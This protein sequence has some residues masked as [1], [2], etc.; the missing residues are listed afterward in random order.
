PVFGSSTPLPAPGPVAVPPAIVSGLPLRFSPVDVGAIQSITALGAMNP[1][2]HT[3]PTDHIYFAHHFNT[4]PFPPV[5][6]V[7]PGS[8]TVESVLERGGDAKI[9][10]RVANQVL[11]AIDHVALSP[12]LAS[13]ARVEA[14]MQIGTSTSGVFDFGI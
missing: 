6:I 7:A 4:G 10:V 8:G 14:G 12:P 1:W 3:L 5:P 13:G 9:S 2:G 11:Y